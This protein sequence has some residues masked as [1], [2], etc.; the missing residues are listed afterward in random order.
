MLGR[1]AARYAIWDPSVGGPPIREFPLSPEGWVEAWEAF[2][3]IEA[4]DPGAIPPLGLGRLMSVAFTTYGRNLRVLALI[5][6]IVVLPYS[7][8]SLGLTL[9]TVRF[10][11]TRIGPETVVGPRIPLWVDV[12]NN[13]VLYAFVVPLLTGAIVTAVV[14]ILLG[15]PA[16]VRSAYRRAVRRGPSV[17]W[18]SLLAALAASAPVIPGIV[19]IRS[20]GGSTPGVGPAV[21]LLTLGLLAGI[22]LAVRLVFAV[23]VVMMEGHRGFDA[24]RRSWGLVRGMSGKVLGGL[25]LS[26]VILFGVLVVAVTVTLTATLFGEP[27]GSMVRLV[28][29]VVSAVSALTVTVVGPLVNVVIV[30]LYLDARGRKEGLTLRHLEAS[31]GD[32]A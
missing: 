4:T 20:A 31:V 6:G 5:S 14:G 16:A 2:R 21:G 13:V 7:A 3:A 11:P 29:V 19:V 28:L 18:A 23:P 22:F 25:A 32:G 27:T 24:L 12:L 26:L 17:V 30:L 10:I 1:T 15:R 9:A 8:L